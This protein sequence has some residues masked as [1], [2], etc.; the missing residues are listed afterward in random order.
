MTHLI[1]ILTFVDLIP[2]SKNNNINNLN[3]DDLNLNPLFLQS[4]Y[5]SKTISKSVLNI[6]IKGID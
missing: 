4:Y 1:S 5:F 3:D 6:Y 2:S